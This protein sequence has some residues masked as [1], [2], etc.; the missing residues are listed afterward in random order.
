[1]QAVQSWMKKKPEI[2]AMILLTPFVLIGILLLFLLGL[3]IL[4][5]FNPRIYLS[6]SSGAVPLGGNINARWT[7]RGRP[8]RIRHLRISIEGA[9]KADYRRGTTNHTD[10]RVFARLPLVDT[11]DSHQIAGGQAQI[12]IPADLMHTFKARNNEILWKIKVHGDVPRFP[13]VADEFPI[14][15]L[16]R[17]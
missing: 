16:P 12:K 10:T 17:A 11:K 7:F 1:V 5:L 6:V 9:E 4:N 14:T 8:R 2:L 15:I 3:C 13:D